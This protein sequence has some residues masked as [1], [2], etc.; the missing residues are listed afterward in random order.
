MHDH[1]EVDP[2]KPAKYYKRIHKNVKKTKK[3]TFLTFLC[4]AMP[5]PAR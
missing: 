1:T 2:K 3:H 4:K 5:D